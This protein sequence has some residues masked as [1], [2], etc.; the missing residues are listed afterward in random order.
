M[1]DEATS[2]DRA[3]RTRLLLAMGLASGITSVP[4]A[5]IVLALPAIHRELGLEEILGF[6]PLKAGLLMLSASVGTVVMMPVGGRL[7]ERV[8]PLLPIVGGMA[9]GGLGLVLLSR[10]SSSTDYADVWPPLALYGVGV[11]VALTPMNLAALNSMPA[12][13][14][15]AVA[16]II[17]TMGGLG[18]TFGVAVS[19]AVFES[20]QIDRVGSAHEGFTSALGTT[21]EL[22]FVVLLAGIA[23]APALIRGEASQEP[24]LARPNMTE[25]FSGLT[26]RP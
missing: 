23:F 6:D 2:G 11:G 15:G 19:G 20:L 4:N 16:A 21:L 22:S 12:R 13:N 1:G 7:Y 25:P 3:G 18:A 24:A 5:A 17:T 9:V 14:H 8:G 26:P 10:I